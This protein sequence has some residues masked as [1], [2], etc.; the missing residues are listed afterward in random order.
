MQLNLLLLRDRAFGFYYPDDLEKLTRAGAE[1]V[2]V[3]AL[4]QQR[5]PPLDGLFIR[6]GFP[7]TQLVDLHSNSALRAEIKQRVRSGLPV[8][9]ECGGLMYLARSLAWRGSAAEMVGALP[10]DCVMLDRPQGRG[11]VKLQ[12]T[13]LAPW[14]VTPASAAS[15]NAHEFHYSVVENIGADVGF[16]YRVLRGHGVDG[17]HDGMV[18]GNV[19]ASYAHLRD[20]AQSPWTSGFIEFVAACQMADKREPAHG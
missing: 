4:S 5:L 3:D 15:L 18:Y 7:E 19:L 11:Y 8:Y 10:V 20:T 12:T 6:G 17:V 1:L 14:S 16:A 13:G 9:A 2:F